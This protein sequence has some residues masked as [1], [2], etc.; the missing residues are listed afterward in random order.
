MSKILILAE[1]GFGKSSSIGPISKEDFARAGF[2]D[3]EIIGVNPKET[4]IISATNKGLPIPRWK[5]FYKTVTYEDFLKTGTGNHII[6]NDGDQIAKVINMIVLGPTGNGQNA[7][8]DIVNIILDDSNY[9]MQDY[10]MSKALTTGYD[11]FKK[12]GAFMGNIFN[13]MEKV[14][15]VKK[16]FIMMAHYEEFKNSNLDTISYRY[17]TVGKMVQDYITPEGK[18]EIVLFGKQ[19]IEND[20]VNKRIVK[21]FVTNF[22]GQYPAKSSIGMFP[23]IYIPND[24]GVVINHIKEYEG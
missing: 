19:S 24:L 8:N 11:V 20:G 14:S 1:S 5:Q 10:Y 16:N 17:K 21:Q 13:A 2:T 15:A 18:F 4:F 23:E 3:R 12:I 6:T 22:D 7:R 9:I